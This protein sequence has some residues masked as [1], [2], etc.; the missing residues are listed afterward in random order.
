M[1]VTNHHPEIIEGLLPDPSPDSCTLTSFGT[2]HPWL[3][4]PEGVFGVLT[5]S[6]ILS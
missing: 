3:S 2:P 5:R 1:I 4:A 6:D